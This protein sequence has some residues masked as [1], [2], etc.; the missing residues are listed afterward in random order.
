MAKEKNINTKSKHVE[1]ESNV[2]RDELAVTLHNALNKSSKD[3]TKS[4]YWVDD[5]DNPS[6]IRDWVSTGSTLLDLAISNRPHGGLPVGRV[7]EL[8]GLEG[9]GKSLMCAHIIR[10]TEK[11][12]GLSVFFDSESAIDRNFWVAL[13]VNIKN[14][15]YCPFTTLEDLFKKVELCIG[16][17]RKSSHDRLLT[18][19]IDSV[20][21]ATIEK[22]LEA[23][24]GI[25]G[26]NTG[27]SLI[28]G[29]AFR[30]I[31]GII[32]R[33]RILVVFTNQLRFNMNSGPFGD[34]WTTPG[35]KSLSYTASTRV[36]LGTI[37]KL[38]KNNEVIGVKCTC[39]VIKSRMGPGARG[40]QFEIHYDSGIQD[41][42]SW[43]NFS[44]ERGII[45]GTAAK[46]SWKRTNGE[47]MEFNTAKFVE[48]MN[49]DKDLK[50]EFY[51]VICDNYIMHY[52][53]PNSKIVEDVEEVSDETPPETESNS[54]E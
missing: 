12:G 13:G 43:L 29:K 5:D 10:E 37:G 1:V 3:G 25:D 34:K 19:F 53:D 54:D 4:A 23:E 17:F 20:A 7:A 11:K 44:K 36:R 40:A 14:T 9:T 38:K 6:I 30:K 42:A 52:R 51:Q 8:S 21:Q 41:L 45:T 22:E 31:T 33:E 49:S 26:Y 15:N 18:I 39:A 27:K 32:S 46:Y 28:L 2:G 47:T 24:H 48:L 16:E 35:G 50:E